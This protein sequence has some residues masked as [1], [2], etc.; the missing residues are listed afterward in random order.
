M[1]EAKILNSITDT[2]TCDK[3]PSPCKAKQNASKATCVRQWS[4]T[5][6]K[7]NP[8]AN[9][10]EVRYEVSEMQRPKSGKWKNEVTG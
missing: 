3:C 2:M 9:W 5:L 7:I 4:E 6:S 1:N 10:K 8:N